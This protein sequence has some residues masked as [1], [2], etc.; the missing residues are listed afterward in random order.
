M[1]AA[2]I[3]RSL[4]SA[5]APRRLPAQQVLLPE[6]QAGP[7]LVILVRLLRKAMALVLTEQVPGRAALGA[8]RLDDL[9]GFGG[10]N[11]G[12][13]AAGNH[14]QRDP[15]LIHPSE[16][17]DGEQALALAWIALVAILHAPQIAAIALRVFKECD[18]VRDGDDAI[19]RLE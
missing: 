15:E 6:H 13:V 12:I 18:E 9:I 3:G 16:R 19:R 10:R 5:R 7:E 4:M 1:I 14:H 8:D 11:P 17:R 2:F